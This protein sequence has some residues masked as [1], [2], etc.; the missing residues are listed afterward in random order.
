MDVQFIAKLIFLIPA[1]FD[2]IEYYHLVRSDLQN[3]YL[4]ANSGHRGRALVSQTREALPTWHHYGH[5]G[6]QG[7][8]GQQWLHLANVH[9]LIAKSKMKNRVLD[10]LTFHQ[11]NNTCLP[12]L[13]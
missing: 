9:H 11:N 4:L 8:K 2:L 13:L 12:Q 7:A 6:C 10:W 1:C 5:T 3:S